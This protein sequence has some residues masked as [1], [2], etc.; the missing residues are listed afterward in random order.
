MMD[1]LSQTREFHVAAADGVDIGCHVSGEGPALLMVHGVAIDHSCFARARPHLAEQFTVYLMDRRGR[2]ISGDAADWS[3][4]R[5]FD[6]VRAVID[7]IAEATGG[8]VNVFGHS[9]GGLCAL[10]AVARPGKTH[11]GN[12]RG[13]FLYDPAIP[14]G[15]R[16]AGLQAIADKL[17]DILR[18][19]GD[20]EKMIETHLLE[21][22]K[23]SPEA[24][25]RQKADTE[26]W[27]RRVGWA[28]TIPREYKGNQSFVLD[29]GRYADI[30]VPTRVMVG[31]KSHDGLQG[32]ARLIGETVPGGELI[33]LK[34]AAH[35]G[36]NT[37][38]E[39]F[40]AEVTK[41]FTEDQTHG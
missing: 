10:E 35:Y 2:G 16:P 33:V 21:W 23:I 40:A 6:D 28:H 34:G 8:P 13:L 19:T 7:A 41:F 11:T 1:A 14:R 9:L 31:E 22:T 15:P 12:V 17:D 32:S 37:A 27:A 39:A 5:E 29:L 18:T 26:R 36:F 38:P 24:L 3:M 4:A 30:R 20:R 25:A